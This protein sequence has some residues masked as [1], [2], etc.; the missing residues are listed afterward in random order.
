MSVNEYK[1]DDIKKILSKIENL[2]EKSH[3]EKVREIIY[4]EN[5]NIDTTKKSSGGANARNL[6]TTLTS[7]DIW[8]HKIVSAA[9][10]NVS[11]LNPIL[12]RLHR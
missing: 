7:C 2:K 1:I 12:A 10:G 9:I 11:W 4:K 6:V 5:P 3:Y 8:S